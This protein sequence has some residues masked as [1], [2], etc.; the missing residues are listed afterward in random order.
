MF[1]KKINYGIFGIKNQFSRVALV[2]ILNNETLVTGFITDESS[3]GM[4]TVFIPTGP[5]PT[6]GMIYHVKDKY[7]HPVDVDATDAIQAIVSCGY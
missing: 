2:Q 4:K 6:S 7:V 5:N 3:N 1:V